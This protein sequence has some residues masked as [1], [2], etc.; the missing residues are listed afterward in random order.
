[1]V[2][3]RLFGERESV[4]SFFCGKKEIELDVLKLVV[5]IIV[6][7]LLILF[8]VGEM[9]VLW[10]ESLFSLF[11]VIVMSFDWMNLL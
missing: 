9:I 8:F 5:K 1:M 10:L 11:W 7:M 2:L 3:F 6:I 4:F